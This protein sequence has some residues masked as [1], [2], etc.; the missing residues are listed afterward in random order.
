MDDKERNFALL[1]EFIEQNGKPC[2]LNLITD[3]DLKFLKQIEKKKHTQA[4]HEEAK[5]H[6]E[7]T[8]NASQY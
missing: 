3:R 8:E 1:Q 7:H 5:H 2:C 4:H 6:E